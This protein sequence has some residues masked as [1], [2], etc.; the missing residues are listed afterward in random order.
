MLRPGN[1][2]GKVLMA[3]L[4]F[5]AIT[6]GLAVPVMIMVSGVSA[7]LASAAGGAVALLAL[8]AA[9]SMRKPRTGYPLGWATQVATL[10]LSFLTIG[11][12]IMGV[13]FAMLWVVCFILGKRLEAQRG[14]T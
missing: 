12:L 4:I 7:G 1:P 8:V 6:I 13:M 2:M 3:T 14:M 11:M 10:A 5:E 9:G